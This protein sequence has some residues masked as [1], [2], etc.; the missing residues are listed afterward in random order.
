MFKHSHLNESISKRFSMSI[1]FNIIRGIM[2]LLTSVFLARSL[3]PEEF[4]R[5]A[6]LLASF[7]AFKAL[8]DMY[9]SHAFFTF[10]SKETRSK[11]FIKI[12]W[13][14]M[15]FQLIFSLILVG[16][17]LP[18]TL[19]ATIWQNQDRILVLLALIAIFMQQSAWQVASYMA[20]ANR[21]TVAMQ[22]VATSVVFCHLLL[23]VFLF[24]I[25]H[26][27]L[28]I[29]FISISIEW[30]LGTFYAVK[31]Y[32]GNDEK[33]DDISSVFNEFWIYCRPLIPLVIFS[34]LYE[35]L[36]RWMLQLWGGSKEQA[37]YALALSFSTIILLATTSIIK[38]FWKEI[39]ESYHNGDLIKM[40]DFYKKTSRT[41]YFIGAFVAGFFIPWS[42]ELLQITVGNDYVDGKTTFILMLIYPVHQ[43]LGQINGAVLLATEKVK[44]QNLAGVIFIIV[45]LLVAYYALAPEGLLIPGLNLGSQGLAWKMIIMQFF[46]VNIISYMIAR[47]FKWKYDWL[48]QF[49]VLGGVL[50]IGFLIKFLVVN[51]LSSLFFS[52]IL[53][54]IIYS[55]TSAICLYV[56]SYQILSIKNQE[57]NTFLNN[58]SNKDR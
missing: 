41:L 11:D 37:Y 48:Y 12:Y 9:S 53:G 3:G 42:E 27:T 58:L 23:I 4:G 16:L 34:F 31:M 47:I 19:V 56:F 20:E 57:I 49:Y 30:A 5:M 10:L 6:F 43:S 18:N 51:F 14:W 32:S 7:L 26:L 44:L 40:Q 46:Q 50:I 8:M 1:F 24:L 17:L 33:S 52:I 2:T 13:Y 35:F 15:A 54:F 39:A 36:D 38:I 45:S 28:P 25:D 55:I 21:A 29:I 22:K